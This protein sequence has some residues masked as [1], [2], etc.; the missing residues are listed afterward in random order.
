MM[1]SMKVVL[2]SDLTYS[3]RG[4]VRGRRTHLSLKA[5]EVLWLRPTGADQKIEPRSFRVCGRRKMWVCASVLMR[6][7]VPDDVVKLRA[8]TH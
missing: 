3:G 4:P 5:G 6:C 1:R 7:V 2:G 8:V